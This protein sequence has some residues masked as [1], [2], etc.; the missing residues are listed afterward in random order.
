MFSDS[1]KGPATGGLKIRIRRTNEAGGTIFLEEIRI[2]LKRPGTL[3]VKVLYELV[4][5]L[6]FYV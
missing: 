3:G 6:W 2:V 5:I 1:S 4:F